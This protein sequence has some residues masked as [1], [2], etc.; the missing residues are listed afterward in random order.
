MD[1]QPEDWKGVTMENGRVVQLDLQEFGLTGAVP[2][3]IGQLRSLERLYL[4]DNKLTSLPAEI[5]QLTSLEKLWLS[6]NQ[7]TSLPAEIG[8]LTSLEQLVLTHNQL[9]SVPAAVDELRAAGCD[10]RTDVGVTVNY[11]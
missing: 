11:R 2:A 7:L 4:N 9:T 6:F 5:W 8:Q 3:E 1:E 10:V